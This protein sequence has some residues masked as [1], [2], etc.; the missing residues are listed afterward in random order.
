[1][2][3]NGSITRRN[4]HRRTIAD[5]YTHVPGPAQHQNPDAGTEVSG[6]GAFER[7]QR[8]T[9]EQKK[10][11]NR[12]SPPAAPLVNKKVQELSTG[13]LVCVAFPRSFAPFLREFDPL[14]ITH[15]GMG[16]FVLVSRLCQTSFMVLCTVQSV[17]ANFATMITLV[18]IV[19]QREL[20]PYRSSSE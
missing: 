1:M 11:V 5:F 20:W 6:C 16:I 18:A 10:R 19:I 14:I 3:K 7:H 13:V 2:T 12:K 4:S 17:Q 15:T 8:Q 9:L